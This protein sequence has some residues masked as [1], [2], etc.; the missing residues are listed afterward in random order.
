MICGV[1]MR[2]TR[3]KALRKHVDDLLQRESTKGEFRRYKKI[4]IQ[5]RSQGKITLLK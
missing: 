3:V 4:Y 5:Q 2:K 1:N